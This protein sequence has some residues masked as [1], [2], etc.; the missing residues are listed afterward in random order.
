MVGH[1]SIP[2]K[3][4]TRTASVE[5]KTKVGHQ[6]LA[7]RTAPALNEQMN[8][9]EGPTQRFGM[10]SILRDF[11]RVRADG[12]DHPTGDSDIGGHPTG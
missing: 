3:S 12:S 8:A 11:S 1:P 2:M 9:Q 5:Q 10:H 7:P 6:K 4:K